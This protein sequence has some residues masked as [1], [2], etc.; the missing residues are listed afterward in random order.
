MQPLHNAKDLSA[1]LMGPVYRGDL[2]GG[3]A[4]SMP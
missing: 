1:R 2:Y 3:I 4:G